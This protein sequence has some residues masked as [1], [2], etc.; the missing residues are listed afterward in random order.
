MNH[1]ME[2]EDIKYRKL[3]QKCPHYSYKCSVCSLYRDNLETAEKKLIFILEDIVD[4]IELPEETVEKYIEVMS[5][6]RYN[7]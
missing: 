5:T 7:D 1:G 2:T 4:T 3:Q 6:Y